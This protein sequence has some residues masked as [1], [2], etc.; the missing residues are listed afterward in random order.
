MYILPGLLQ[1]KKLVLPQIL[2]QHHEE[3]WNIAKNTRAKD[4]PFFYA[5]RNL[6]KGMRHADA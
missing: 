3:D 4:R 2:Q 6:L 5:T 1:I